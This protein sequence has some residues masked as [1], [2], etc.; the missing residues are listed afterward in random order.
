MLVK[1][2]VRGRHGGFG[3]GIVP[4]RISLKETKRLAMSKYRRCVSFPRRASLLTVFFLFLVVSLIGGF[5]SASMERAFTKAK[6]VVGFDDGVIELELISALDSSVNVVGDVVQALTRE[7]ILVERTRKLPAGSYVEGRITLIK[8]QQEDNSQA[9]LAFTLSHIRGPDGNY[10]VPIGTLSLV[11]HERENGG[12]TRVY[13]SQTDGNTLTILSLNEDVKLSVGSRINL[14][15]DRATAALVTAEPRALVDKNEYQSKKI[16]ENRKYNLSQFDQLY[17]WRDRRRKASLPTI[18]VL[19]PK[20]PES[21]SSDRYYTG[22]LWGASSGDYFLL[23]SGFD[24][25]PGFFGR[26]A[27]FG[28]AQNVSGYLTSLLQDELTTALSGSRKFQV[29]VPATGYGATD[30]E[31]ISSEKSIG[32]RAEEEPLDQMPT[33]DFYLGS[34]IGVRQIQAE[35]IGASRHNDLDALVDLIFPGS[36]SSGG[37]RNHVERI[38][39]GF[40][41]EKNKVLVT[42]VTNAYIASDRVIIAAGHGVGAS[43]LDKKKLNILGI[44]HSRQNVDYVLSSAIEASVRDL[45]GNIAAVR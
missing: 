35:A 41:F 43:E 30:L 31:S 9:C 40:E 20:S 5:L 26:G 11:G 27:S 6:T 24:A 37:I 10:P 13:S 29:L 19:E 36:H 8:R 32:W 23:P 34:S 33:A 21:F 12:N 1:S 3:A 14:R 15:V 42:V 4:N 2:R 39:R 7:D 16:Q 17:P 28:R 22:S 38:L 45:L 44:E 18:V 25:N